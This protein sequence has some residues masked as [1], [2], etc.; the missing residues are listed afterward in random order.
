VI[1]PLLRPRLEFAA[2]AF[3]VASF[4]GALTA[5]VVRLQQNA[6]ADEAHHADLGRWSVVERPA[7]CTVDDVRELRDAT[8][9]R[10]WHASLLHP[11]SGPVVWRSLELT[12]RV[13][14][15]AGMRRRF[16]DEFEAVIELRRPVAAVQ[17]GAGASTRW[18]EVDADGRALSPP[19]AA[20]PARSLDASGTPV[21]ARVI[22]GAAGVA[23]SPG[24]CFG[25]DVAAAADLV[26]ELDAYGTPEDRKLLRTL[27]EVD[28]A[29]FAG[30]V[31]PGA[32][33]I[34]LRRTDAGA[35]ASSA[36]AQR[37]C[38]VEWGRAEP[39]DP[40]DAEASFGAKAA[41]VAQALRMFPALAGLR[42]VKVAFSDLV[43]VPAPGSPLAPPSR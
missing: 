42:T 26:A 19:L 29:N 7:W 38:D 6:L 24:A 40:T 2:K 11:G 33:E 28:V 32:S 14:R 12:P 31:R 35:A 9:L 27:D 16:P 20:R 22:R 39:A 37:P 30:R 13:E 5:G 23:A 10:G 41:R 43:V 21:P 4:L 17:V 15:V 3:L 36:R 1:S 34:I 8:R 25:A 18:I